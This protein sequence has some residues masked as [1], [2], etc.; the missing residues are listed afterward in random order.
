VIGRRQQRHTSTV[1]TNLDCGT[2]GHCVLN[3]ESD[4]NLFRQR[5]SRRGARVALVKPTFRVS[6]QLVPVGQVDLL[7]N[8]CEF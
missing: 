7:S 2:L 8:S 3:P 6:D 4:R 5:W 1:L